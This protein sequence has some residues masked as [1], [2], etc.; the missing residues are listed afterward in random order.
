[1][2][3][4]DLTTAARA[5]APSLRV[6]D[7]AAVVDAVIFEIAMRLHGSE[8][9]QIAGFGTFKAI[10]RAARKGRNP[11]TGDPINVPAK[12]VVKFKPSKALQAAMNPP[13]RQRQR[14]RA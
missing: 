3:M 6:S 12:N 13:Q 14:K 2:S 10:R 7:A 1:M 8:D 5:A 11:Q 4:K 9:F